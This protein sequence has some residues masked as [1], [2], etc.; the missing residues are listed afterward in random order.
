MVK[1]IKRKKLNM[2]RIVS[3]ILTVLITYLSIVRDCTRS[4]ILSIYGSI[5]TYISKFRIIA[6]IQ[7]LLQNILIY[8]LSVGPVPEHVSFIMDGNRRYA[9]SQNLPL[10]RGHEAGGFTLLT[11]VYICKKI[12]VRCVSAYA[13]SIENFNR[14]KEEVDTLME[15][16]T[17]KLEEF[18]KRANDF[19]DPLY[20]SQLRIV[21]DRSLLSPSLKAKVEEVELIT[22]DG[23]DFVLYIC[24]PYTSRNDIFKTV[25][26]NVTE[27][28]KTDQNCKSQE[29]LNV[30]TFTSQMYLGNFSNKCDLLIRTSGHR[31]LSDYMLWQTHENSTIEFSDVLWPDFSFMHMY[32]M[33]L[34]WSFFTTIQNYN[35]TEF[36]VV[37]NIKDYA[38]IFNKPNNMTLESLP[39]PPIAISIT[40]K[41][42]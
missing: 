26:Q 11:L 28:S 19:K 7:N 5:T 24:F 32:K 10:K 3:Y 20:G 36:S 37:Q 13:F 15:L 17:V 6:Y 34:Q 39:D 14:P 41:K 2:L 35:E 23:K 29:N 16:F 8:T 12:G 38:N 30:K 40:G 1:I 22:K 21:G 25:H 4:R 18:S 33:M 27:L 42:N 9:K 31:R